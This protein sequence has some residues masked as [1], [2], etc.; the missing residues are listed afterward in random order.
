VLAENA[1]QREPLKRRTRGSLIALTLLCC[2]LL[3]ALFLYTR[4][5]STAIEPTQQPRRR[6]QRQPARRR[7]ATSQTQ[8]RGRAAAT[9][10]NYAR[11]K[12]EDHRQP[13]A[14][15]DCADCHTIPSPAAPDLVAAA[16]KPSV[17]GYP[18]HDS[19]VRCHR[20][21]F[22]KGA[23]PAICTVCHT[24]ASP[25]LTARDMHTF[26]KQNES[27]I[28]REFPGYFPHSLHQRVIAR[29]ETDASPAGNMEES[30]EFVRASFK[31]FDE[32]PA[33]FSDNCATCHLT[34][35]RAPAPMAIGAAE[36]TFKPEAKGTFKTVP[37][38]HAACF[39][40]HWQ[41]QKPLKDDCAGCHLSQDEYTKK[42]R[43]AS[44]E[45]ALPGVLSPKAVE[46][47]KT[48]PSGWPKRLSLKF[49]HETPNHDIGCT[50]C[51]INLTQMETLNIPK[52]DVPVATCAICHVRNNSP[53]LRKEGATVTFFS[54]M[55]AEADDK[56]N[57]TN[58]CTGC[59]TT[60]IGRE[61][62]PCSHYLVLGQ[63]C[64]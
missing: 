30:R 20:Q 9:A 50:T 23:S 16:T 61:R 8:A 6:A 14:K 7:P 15:L 57:K 42:K 28:A 2:A 59:H 52:A 1:R 38:G 32:P 58:T 63:P 3:S 31:T 12:H 64:P 33:K 48:W 10:R 21:Q 5:T 40:C 29:R 26:P 11:F 35:E 45:A 36:A 27:A 46:W 43:A 18:Y 13:V 62:P 4:A 24:R 55:T 51:H 60:Q 47:F 19:C 53:V 37:S 49:R 34:D 22:F 17:N 25:R 39:N 54:E 44:P 56:E 41:S